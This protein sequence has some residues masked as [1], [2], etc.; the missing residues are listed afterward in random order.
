MGR[1]ILV[2][3][4]DAGF[5][6][7][8]IISGSEGSAKSLAD[9]VGAD[10][11]GT[12]YNILTED[13]ELIVIAVPD[14]SLENVVANLASTSKFDSETLIVHTSGIQESKILDSL[15]Q[16][17]AKIASIHP[18]ASFPQNKILPLRDVRFGVEGNN[19]E[20]AA[21]LVRSI[22][23]I[24]FLIETGKKALYHAACTVASGYLNTLLTVSEELMEQA[25]VESPKNIIRD[26]AG[27]ALEGWDEAG[28]SAITGSIARGDV[29][30][31]R[32]HVDSM[33]KKDENRAVYLQM[34]FKTVELC[35]DAG[36]ID[37]ETSLKLK[38]ILTRDKP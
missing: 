13:S 14:D 20:E 15:L 7:S 11:Y 35:R 10:N 17:G 3:L 31:V 2:S 19:S 28:F 18:A 36:L 12:S 37:E 23:G 27:S 4:V 34:A 29:D 30:S 8:A 21:E 9:I 24:P 25:G 38:S 5:T 16:K 6:P 22:G 32:K 33:G 26:L 1:S